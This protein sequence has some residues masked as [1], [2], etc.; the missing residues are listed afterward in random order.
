MLDRATI[1][2]LS[3]SPEK[4][5][6]ILNV[7]LA[8]EGHAKVLLALAR[9][10]SVGPEALGVIGQRIDADGKGVGR[11]PDARPDEPF[12]PIAD[13]LDRLLVAQ[14]FAPDEVRDAILGRHKDDPYFV[15]AAAGHARAT[16]AAIA[17]AASWPARSAVHDRLWIALI[18]ASRLPPLTAEEWAQDPSEYLREAIAR[19][20]REAALLEALSR[21]ASRRVRRAVASNRFAAKERAR[22]AA[23]DAAAEVR[24]RAAGPLSAHEG[25]PEGGNLVDTARFAAALRAMRSFGVLPPDV[26]QALVTA[27]R[28]LDSEGAAL[29]ARVLA[30]HETFALLEQMVETGGTTKAALG[31]AA[32]L[33]LR[34][35]VDDEDES[36]D[37][38]AELTSFIYD[39]VKP[40][41]RLPATAPG[42]TGKA[43]LSAWMA[44]GLAAT[45]DV[46]A[47]DLA[48]QAGHG[49]LASGGLVLARAAAKMP[50]LVADL[51]REGK[52][53]DV[54]PAALLSLAWDDP[55]VPD[56]AVIE[57]AGRVQKPKKRAEDL[58]DD[59][60]DLDPLSRS[61]DVL[62]RAVLSASLRVNVSPR[63]ALAV[64]ALDSRRVR[65][66]LAAMPSWKGRLSGGKLARVVRAN[67]GALTA[68]Q[69][70]A[71]ARGAK[72][73]GWTARLLSEIELAIAIAVGHV[74]SE[75]VAARLAS[76]RQ[77]LDDGLSLAAGV[78]AR[79]A[80]E[81]VKAVQPVVE[82]ATKNRGTV[83]SA[84]ALWLLLE[85]L[86]RSRAPSTI[87]SS[88]DNV[89]T[90]KAGVPASVC[91][92]LVTLEHRRPGKLENIG[93][94]SPRGRATLASAIARA[95]RTLGG[96]RDERLDT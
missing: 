74:T 88:I 77:Q 76:G 28:E 68:A 49:A 44:E 79:A 8:E 3:L 17:R 30:S 50:S 73:E 15:L 38:E 35:P 90:S 93:P 23:E 80:V 29:A 60:V 89:A 34:A 43:K 6:P 75:E 71:R 1:E 69:A 82:W 33:A 55:S 85:Q 9:C 31:F 91:D 64:I 51:V 72:V 18:D 54:V 19:T 70:E 39:A 57:I 42:L 52:K 24:A 48:L 67:A 40:A 16:L 61:L 66:V 58:P 46:T 78:H 2:R 12:E 7:A 95:Y 83:P 37:P 63:S 84:L 20:T 53:V 10:R 45:P 27:G 87:A 26:R 32:G 94:Q 14:P 4:N 47:A 65:Y 96:L 25:V 81:G 36:G 21:D 22:L 56:A 62:E 86:D 59:E 11:D 41:Q 13:E 92:A 5:D